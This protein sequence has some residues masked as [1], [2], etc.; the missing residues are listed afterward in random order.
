MDPTLWILLMDPTL[1]ILHYGSYSMDPTLWILL[2][3][4]TLWILLYDSYSVDPILWILPHDP[5]V[6]IIL[7]GFYSMDTTLLIIHY[8]PYSMDFTPFVLV[9][10]Y[11]LQDKS[12]ILRFTQHLICSGSVVPTCYTFS[13]THRFCCWILNKI[14]CYWIL[15]QGPHLD[16][17]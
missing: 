10:Y 3:D 1:W 11:H 5:T 17:K 2:M 7:Y 16:P 6:W 8:G 12:C 9:M 15:Q 4:P 14:C 13:V